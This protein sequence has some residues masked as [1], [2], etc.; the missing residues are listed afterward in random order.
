MDWCIGS[1]D[2]RLAFNVNS[3]LLL[4]VDYHAM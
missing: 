3:F 1:L 2:A 4:V